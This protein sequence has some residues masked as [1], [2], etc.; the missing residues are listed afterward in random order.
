MATY[1]G[2]DGVVKIGGTAV[3]EV[4]AFNVAE[5]V[6]SIDTTP[7]GVEWRTRKAGHKTWSG[8]LSCNLDHANAQHLAVKTA[9]NAG[10]D[11]ALI[12]YAG[13]TTTGGVTSTLTGN[14][15]VT[16]RT[17]TSPE[18]SAVTTVEFTFEG[19]GILTEAV[20]A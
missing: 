1:R 18:G 11:V 15:V 20:I 14:A 19:N 12:L 9:I 10:T 6:E 5:T 7:K 13:G 8:S 16:G 17:I 3:G 2:Q 4:T